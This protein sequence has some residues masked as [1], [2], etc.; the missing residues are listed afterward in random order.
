M[1]IILSLG[2]RR[3]AWRRISTSIG[4]ATNVYHFSNERA[5]ANTIPGSL[6]I[7]QN[8]NDFGSRAVSRPLPARLAS[9]KCTR[10][11]AFCTI[12]YEADFNMGQGAVF[13]IYKAALK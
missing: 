12:S 3:R 6:E 11:R 4:A 2:G 13:M 1:V 8:A 9:T 5:T 7:A 10:L